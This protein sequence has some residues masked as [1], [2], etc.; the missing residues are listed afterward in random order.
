M[1]RA[2]S[3]LPRIFWGIPVPLICRARRSG[4][5]SAP[6]VCASAA[7]SSHECSP[8]AAAVAVATQVRLVRRSQGQVPRLGYDER[9]R[10]DSPGDHHQPLGR[11]RD[12]PV[13][14]CRT[15]RPWRGRRAPAPPRSAPGVEVASSVGR[16]RLQPLGTLG[17]AGLART[18]PASTCSRANA[19]SG[20]RPITGTS[21]SSSVL[22]RTAAGRD[23]V[24]VTV[25]H[26]LQR[27]GRSGQHGTR[28]RTP[29]QRLRRLLRRGPAQPA[30]A[31]HHVDPVTGRGEGR[32]HSLE[33][34]EPGERIAG[35]IGRRVGHGG[36]AIG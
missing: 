13:V 4:L 18:P 16:Q 17:R 6:F 11:P 12:D 3:R 28:V 19:C 32:G 27:G 1:C 35:G 26:L 10:V 20:E 2:A 25:A 22:T 24:A 14:R 34:G 9:G 30:V 7:Y 36:N 21:E 29:Q 15:A 33:P 5:D 8:L 23:L 31:Q